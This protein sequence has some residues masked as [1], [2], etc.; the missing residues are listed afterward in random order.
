MES[1]YRLVEFVSTG[2]RGVVL[3]KESLRWGK[4]TMNY[5]NDGQIN[6]LN[7]LLRIRN[8]EIVQLKQTIE[9]L[10]KTIDGLRIELE[11]ARQR[12]AELQFQMPNIQP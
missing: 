3:L 2:I 7:E 1:Y 4:I 10:N 8:L 11:A 5:R 6:A 12:N 9:E